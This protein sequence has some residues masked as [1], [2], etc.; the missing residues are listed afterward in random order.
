MEF[1]RAIPPLLMQFAMT[2]VFSF[3]VGLEF[4]RYH[5][6]NEYKLHFGST[7]TFVLIGILGFI[8]NSIRPQPVIVCGGPAAVE[9][10]FID[11]LLATFF[12]KTLFA[13][14]HFICA[15]DLFDWPYRQFFSGLVFSTLYCLA[16]PVAR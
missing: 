10:F 16:D 12:G 4:R 11:F 5:H 7:R 6:A 13:V 14:E 15:A 1:Y 3:I 2:V 8:L 9:R